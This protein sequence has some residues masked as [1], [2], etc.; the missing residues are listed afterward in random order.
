MALKVSPPSFPLRNTGK[1]QFGE[2]MKSLL[3]LA[4]TVMLL[5]ILLSLYK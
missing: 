2:M 1:L 3:A 5:R 4:H